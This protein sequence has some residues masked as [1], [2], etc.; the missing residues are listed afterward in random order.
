MP[1]DF[2][3]WENVTQRRYE[4]PTVIYLG[5]GFAL[6]ARHVGMGE[7]FLRGE[8]VRPVASAKHTLLNANGSP[9]DALLF[10]VELPEGFV[11]LPSVP[12]ATRPPEVGEEVLMIG[13]GRVRERTTE[14]QTDGPTSFGFAWSE[15]GEKRWGTNR[16]SSVG[17][18]L[19]QEAWATLTF[20]VLFDPPGT[21]THT[22]HEA[23]ATVGD[24]GGA[25]F[26]KRDGEWLLAGL[27]TSITGYTRYPVRT[28]LYG[29][30]TFSA[31]LSAYREEILHWARPACSNEEDDD[32]DGAI[33][34]PDDP[35]CANPE[36]RLER[37]TRPT[38]LVPGSLVAAAATTA[39]G[40]TAHFRRARR[41]AHDGA[42]PPA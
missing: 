15:R 3:Y 30:T 25:V 10:E 41:L 42:A 8:I 1:P 11:E 12:I 6:T 40:L 22:R 13:F 4:S 37:D 26:V 29:D 9:A 27:M 33:D 16:V 36:D 23:Q 24:S 34:H 38:W 21:P 7:I 14:V 18:V 28:S 2:P 39:L 20:A 31:D 17:D 19:H 35:G 32:G 5:N